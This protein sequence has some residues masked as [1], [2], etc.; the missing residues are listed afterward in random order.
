VVYGVESGSE[1]VRREVMQRHVSD[2]RLV[3]SFRW[4]REAGMLATA[5]YIIGTPGETAADIE[6]T[7]AL[8]ER[9][10]PDDFGCFVFYPYPGTALFRTCLERGLLP[11]DWAERPANHRTSILRLPDLTPEQIERYY[12]RF[13]ALRERDQLRRM[14]AAGAAHATRIAADNAASAAIG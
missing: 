11:P 10:A 7:L 4:T 6:R 5:N 14:G 1:R 2:Q 8:H 9:L 13:T 12:A 3:D